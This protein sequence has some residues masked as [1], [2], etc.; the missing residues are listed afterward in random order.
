M[1]NSDL[2]VDFAVAE[3]SLLAIVAAVIGDLCDLPAT[4]VMVVSLHSETSRTNKGI[5]L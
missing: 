2:E 3:A 1:D 5:E 4:C